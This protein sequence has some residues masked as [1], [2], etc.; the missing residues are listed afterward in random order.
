MDQCKGQIL[1]GRGIAYEERSHILSY[2]GK[3]IF[4]CNVEGCG[5]K[6]TIKEVE[7]FE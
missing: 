2:I 5:K 4:E 6:F 7:E 1:D 3:G